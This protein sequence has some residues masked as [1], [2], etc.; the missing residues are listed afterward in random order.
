VSSTSTLVPGRILEAGA[1]LIGTN[2]PLWM[3]LA[4][5]FGFAMSVISSEDN[6]AAAGLEMPLIIDGRHLTDDEQ[7]TLHKEMDDVFQLWG[8]NRKSFTTHGCRGRR[9]AR[10]SST[11]SRWRRRFRRRSA[12]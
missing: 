6:Y 1:E 4:Q 8:R 5:H 3:A 10:R 2:H 12:R 9:M 11:P 7:E